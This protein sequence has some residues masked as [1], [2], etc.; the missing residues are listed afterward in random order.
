MKKIAIIG[1]GVAAMSAAV[2]ALRANADVTMFAPYGLGGL[3][4]TIDKIDNFPSETS[5]DGW[6][7]SQSFVAQIKALGLKPLRERVLALTKNGDEF[8]IVTD[9]AEYEFDSVVVASGTAHN[10]LG[11][12]AQWV[13]RGVS[14]CA[15]CDGNFYR[16][17]TV[18]VVGGGG[19]A[20]REA[21]YLSDVV[22]NV[23][24]FVSGDKLTADAVSTEQL[25]AK[26]N[27][28]IVY[29][30]TVT[31]I[32]GEDVVDG[33]EVFIGGHT[34]KTDVAA[35]FVAIGAKPVTEFVQVDGVKDE[36]GYL[37]IDER[38]QT[39]VKGLFA[40]GDVTNGPLKQIVTAC[41]DGAKAGFFACR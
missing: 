35:V 8:H 26:E 36:K 17:K 30:V 11:F 37:K 25:V 31:A 15:T 14:Y 5:T 22:A 39:A 1:G 34:E 18:A 28:R 12:E 32:Y 41:G 2:Y 24:V 3:V 40:A 23:V 6:T 29:G 16:G 38:C 9:K 13:G 33:V 4:A 20:V 10:K 27:V 7:L 21:L 19:Q